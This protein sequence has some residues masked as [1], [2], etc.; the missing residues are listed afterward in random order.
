MLENILLGISGFPV[1]AIHIAPIIGDINIQQAQAPKPHKKAFQ[2]FG[3]GL[4]TAS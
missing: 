4:N 3:L 2:N 1:D